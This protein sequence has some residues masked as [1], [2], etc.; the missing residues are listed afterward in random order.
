MRQHNKRA[1]RASLA[2]GAL[3]VTCAVLTGSPILAT[4]EEP[5]AQVD[6]NTQAANGPVGR[7]AALLSV[8]KVRRN[9]MAGRNVVV[10]RLAEQGA[11]HPGAKRD[12]GHP[13]P[14]S[15]RLQARYGRGWK[16]VDKALTAADGSYRLK[17]RPRGAGSRSLRILF[18]G[19]AQTVRTGR[20]LGRANVYRHALA[21][22]YGPGLYGNRLGCGGRLNP[23]TVGVAHKTLPCG[24]K[25]TLRH[26]GNVVR[27][28]VIDRG[29]FVGAREFDLTAATKA[30]LGF[31]STGTVLVAA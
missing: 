14:Q 11:E 28:R 27:T 13:G 22:W 25:V 9:I 5:T 15:V 20:Q 12:N 7:G 6:P 2:G 18:K 17:W 4:A 26:K 16:T 30:K 8:D 19:D 1:K 31:G 29:P 23:G 24:T 10:R 21:S 3:T